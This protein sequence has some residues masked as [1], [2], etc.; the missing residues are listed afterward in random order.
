MKRCSCRSVGCG[1]Y[2]SAKSCLSSPVPARPRH[3][4]DRDA[5]RR[6]PQG[7]Q[8]R[9]AE[10]G[11]DDRPGEVE[12]P[13]RATV[14]Q[15]HATGDRRPQPMSE[16]GEHPAQDLRL[17][18]GPQIDAVRRD[19]RVE[20]VPRAL[21]G[22]EAE[23]DGRAEHQPG[24]HPAR[25]YLPPQHEHQRAQLHRLLDQ[26]DADEHPQ[27]GV[28]Q[29]VLHRRGAEN[30]QRAAGQEAAE[31]HA[32][33]E[34]LTVALVR[35]QHEGHRYQ[36]AAEQDQGRQQGGVPGGVG[37]ERCQCPQPEPA[38]QA[39]LP[40]ARPDGGYV[41]GRCFGPGMRAWGAPGGG[42]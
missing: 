21:Q 8:Q 33:P 34:V 6:V 24:P 38:P 23:A 36:E 41:G 11:A 14:R 40:Q 3:Q 17:Q 26:S 42:E 16:G 18:Q 28:E 9:D 20:D 32:D 29:V 2:P 25:P 4:P 30:A 1:M 5:V 19:G 37:D 31:D 13:V 35:P 22:G 12:V 15:Q 39:V 7:V 27:G 10:T